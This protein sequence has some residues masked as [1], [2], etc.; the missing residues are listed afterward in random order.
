LLDKRGE[1]EGETF[2]DLSHL[3]FEKKRRWKDPETNRDLPQRTPAVKLG[4]GKKNAHKSRGKGAE[5]IGGEIFR[6]RTLG[7]G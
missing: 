3:K 7:P 5:K 1:T 6:L 4:E 2:P